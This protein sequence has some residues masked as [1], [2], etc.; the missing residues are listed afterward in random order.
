MVNSL[1]G[2][3]ELRSLHEHL[4]REQFLRAIV[5]SVEVAILDDANAP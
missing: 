1:S 3:I 2:N 5:G 4:D